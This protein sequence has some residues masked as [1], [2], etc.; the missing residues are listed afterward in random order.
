MYC[1][2]NKTALSSQQQIVDALFTLLRE[3]PY[4]AISVS[5]I[6][7]H[8][9]ISRQTFYSL[10]QSKDNVITFALRNDCCYS[11]N[12]SPSA[13]SHSFRQICNGF[14]RYIIQH[15]TV[16]EI[17]TEYDL[18]PLLKTVLRD[19]FSKCFPRNLCCAPNLQPYIIDYLASGI[20]SIAETFI[21]TGQRSNPAEL[22]D[23]IY[24]LMRGGY[25]E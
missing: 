23:I 25:G 19:D 9:G 22:E 17:L 18:M 10:F 4:N 5:T 12:E 8:A 13:C 15:A 6:C 11:A 3:K 14:G 7:S 16:L 20:A 24:L 1:G 2:K 21:R